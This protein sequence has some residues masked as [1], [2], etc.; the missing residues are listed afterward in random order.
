[1]PPRSILRQR[2]TLLALALTLGLGAAARRTRTRRG[3]PLGP[4]RAWWDNRPRLPR[5]RRTRYTRTSHYLTMR[6]GVQIA[7]DVYLPAD[8]Q[9]GAK[10][11]TVL[12]QTRYYRRFT[13]RP[14]FNR[15]IPADPY[16]GMIRPFIRAG[17]AWVAIDARGS[18]A[19]TGTREQEWSPDEVRDGAEVMDWIVAQP[20]SDGQVAAVGISYEGTAAELAG[21][22]R[23]P[24][25]KAISPRFSHFDVYADLG[26]PGG[27]WM[28]KLA[29]VWPRGN[30][31]L[32]NGHAEEVVGR[33]G[34]LVSPRVAPVDD[35]PTGA[36][37]AAAI[38]EHA[39]NYDLAA[40]TL[41]LTY[42][43]DKVDSGL[44]EA[45]MS[46]YPQAADVEAAGIPVYGFSGWYDGGNTRGAVSRYLTLKNP[47]SRLILGPWP[48]AGLTYLAPLVP[49]RR[50]GFDHVGELL[51]FLDYHLRGV[52]TGIAA[53][54]PVHYY[55]TGEDRWK[56]A[57]SWPPPADLIPH[58][59]AESG[60]LA[61][62]APTET[63][64]DAY[65]VDPTIGSGDSARWDSIYKLT[66]DY[67]DRAEID[68]RL[69][70]YTS[71]TLESDVEVTGHPI[72][73]LY[74][75]STATDGQ[76]FVYL[77]D[78]A[79]DGRVGYVTEG[80]LR[81]IHRK[82]SDDP[83]YKTPVPYHSY[84]RASAEPL[85]PGEVAELVI[86]LL[87]ISHL[88]L[89]GHRIRIAL[90]GADRDHCEPLPGDPPTLK[91]Y[92]GGSQASRVDLPVVRRE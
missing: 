28:R 70:T 74:V 43:D 84:L 32:D 50:T 76:F 72:A 88:F 61:R 7:A 80:L 54:P 86:D 26:F 48:H 29:E 89:R 82:L 77:E 15:L 31:A 55:T 66:C 92:R 53:E 35:D 34:R 52:D 14:P 41:G 69:L 57:A 12:R 44:T 73:T 1:M 22:T 62:E 38:R 63:C 37:A 91:V 24:A 78:V 4:D 16:L 21:T 2:W 71:P 20:W 23:H 46:P 85:V 10:V 65:R 3:A 79:P 33:V 90:A 11:P 17:Y 8:L 56:A 25:L 51:R 27:I 45:S 13:F 6:D 47:G 59:F 49:P 81:G 5:P 64:H 30:K 87:P 42:R 83:P 19:S 39:A 75:E 36:R 18:G 67:P 9:P 40:V 58:Y 68:Q 60:R